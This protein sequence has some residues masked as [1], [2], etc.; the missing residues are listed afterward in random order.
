[1]NT[2][3]LVIDIQKDYFPGGRMEVAGALSASEA[4][5]LLL[6][7]FRKKGLPVIHI[8]HLS[9]RAGAAF[10]LPGTSGIEFH[11]NVKPLPGEAVIRKNFPNS[12]RDT[13]LSSL[14]QQKRTER[15]VICGMM[16]Q[17]CVDTTVRA[18]FDAGYQCVVAHDACAARSLTFHEIPVPA[19]HVHA[20]YMAALGAVFA[21]VISTDEIIAH[22]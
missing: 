15:L 2:A 6:S 20:A 18:A 10:L 14:L 21:K 16:S 5:G 11:Q 13:G 8:Q 3:L 4:A 1:M 9:T 19:E 17:M 7:A 22:L 12:F